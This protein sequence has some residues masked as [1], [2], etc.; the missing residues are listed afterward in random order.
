MNDPKPDR[1]N[2]ALRVVRYLKNCPGQGIL[3]RANTELKLTAWCDAEWGTCPTTRRS[4]TAWFVQ[5]NGSPL[6]WKTK[7]HD[8]VSRSSTEAEYRARADTVN[9]LIWLR[10]FLPTLDITCAE[11]IPLHSDMRFNWHPIPFSMQE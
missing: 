2:A 9:E 11:P 6:S 7:K 3:L 4:L 5:L 10:Q 8:R 1:W